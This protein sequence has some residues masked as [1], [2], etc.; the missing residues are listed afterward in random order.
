MV[1]K[2]RGEEEVG[3]Y[4][5]QSHHASVNFHST[6]FFKHKVETRIGFTER[7]KQ[8]REDHKWIEQIM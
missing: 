6:Y 4:M 8:I 3:P 5:K 7:V 2:A 1:G